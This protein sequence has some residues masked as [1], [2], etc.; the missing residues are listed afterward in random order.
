[1]ACNRMTLVGIALLLMVG[2]AGAATELSIMMG[3]GELEWRTMRE[4]IFPP[5]E[6]QHGVTIR[7]IQAEAADAVKK[8]VAMHRAGRM[9]V[10]L[11]AQDV[12][13]LQPL[14]DGGVM[15]DL[16]AHQGEIPPTA[17]AQL[18]QVGTFNGVSYFMPYRPNVQIAYY[19]DT[20][21]AAYG[22]QPP[23]TWDELLAVA[24]RFKAEEGI[25][26]VLLHGTLD[27]NTTTHVVEFIWAAGG[28]PLVLNDPGSVQAFTFLQQ[29]GPALA[30][31]TRRANW[32][33]TNTFLAME[34]VYLARNWPFGVHLLVQQAGKTQI[35][36]YS[37]WGGPMRQAHVLG[38]EVIGIP[39]GAPHRELALQF[40]RYLMSK[41][42]QESLVSAL[43]WP[44]FRSDAYGTIEPWQTPYFAAVQEALSQARPRPQVPNWA[45]VDRALS[46]A[47]REIVYEGL[48]VQTTLD[49]YHRQLQSAQLWSK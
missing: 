11:I 3:L 8:L 40:M 46:G 32:N 37:G 13:L 49:R 25:G 35:K 18:V 31:E 22:L 17:L 5:F 4:R 7:G 1:M 12:L 23:R 24:H 39:R 28:D 42:V 20:K 26:R 10:D 34:A 38:G 14:V 47:F 36:A 43:G 15:A 16:S 44:S 21:F 45:E 29:L 9:Q 2:G 48:P 33:T 30:P 27:L 41:P 19:H 6:Q